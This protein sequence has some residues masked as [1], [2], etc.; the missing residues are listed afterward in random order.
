[1][2]IKRLLLTII[3]IGLPGLVLAQSSPL[4]QAQPIQSTGVQPAPA[5]VPANTNMTPLP[6]LMDQ[7]VKNGRGTVAVPPQS[8]VTWQQFC[9]TLSTHQ[10][11]ADVAYNPGVDAH[12][13]AV[14]PA[15]LPNTQPLNLPQAYSVYITTDQM[16]RLGLNIPNV[17][18]KADTFVGQAV[19]GLDGQVSFNGQPVD[20]GQLYT[21]CGN[22]PR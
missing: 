8:I 11:R 13:R 4:L 15:D 9:Q 2:G 17:P 3:L 21:I 12:G 7:V 10:P 14:A 5:T 20:T 1:M 19:V 18:M 22:L 6:P 16:Q